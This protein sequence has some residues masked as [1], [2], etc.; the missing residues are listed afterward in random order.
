M[1]PE[2]CCSSGG[3]SWINTLDANN[4]SRLSVSPFDYNL[5][6]DF[7]ANDLLEMA[8]NSP[9]MP[10]SS[11]RALVDGG[12][13]IYSAPTQLSLGNGTVQQ[14]VSDSEGDLIRLRESTA[15]GWR[16]WLQLR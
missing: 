2:D 16:N 7:D 3:V 4:G 10:G 12:T 13:G 9:A 6:G 14:I 11:I 5:D 1:I 15:L 8:D